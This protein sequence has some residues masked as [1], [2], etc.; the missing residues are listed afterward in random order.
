MAILGTT[1]STGK[2]L[3]GSHNALDR[4]APHERGRRVR[5]WMPRTIAV[6]VSAL[7]TYNLARSVDLDSSLNPVR[8][9]ATRTRSTGASSGKQLVILAEADADQFA[10]VH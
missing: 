3:P 8:S 7:A 1:P 5:Q 10:A 9:V 6:G 2:R 4:D